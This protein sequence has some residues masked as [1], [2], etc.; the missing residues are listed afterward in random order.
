MASPT[1]SVEVKASKELKELFDRV[2]A[3][4][5]ERLAEVERVLI[6]ICDRQGIAFNIDQPKRERVL[7]NVK[8]KER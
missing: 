8:E 1:V 7:R 2:P 5:S 6:E 3:G 4:L